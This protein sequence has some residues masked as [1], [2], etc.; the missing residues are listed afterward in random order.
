MADFKVIDVINGD[1]LKLSPGWTWK[2]NPE[3][4][5]QGE[6]IKIIGITLPTRNTYEFNFTIEK[7]KKLLINKEVAIKNPIVLPESSNQDALIAGRI[8][9]NDVDVANYFPEY[10]V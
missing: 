8:V 9:L 4:T 6:T 5:I 7:L 1:T 3:K 2:V 10:K